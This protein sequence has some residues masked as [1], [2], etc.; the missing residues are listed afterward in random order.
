MFA[1]IEAYARG[2]LRD[3][4][5]LALTLLLP[6]IIYLLFAAIFGAGGQ[7]NIDAS[8]AFADLARSPA[9]QAARA[10]MRTSF[11]R[12]SERDSA[13]A[14]EASV[15]SGRADT[16][17]VLRTGDGPGLRIEI[18]GTGGREAATN[19]VAARMSAIHAATMGRTV[20]DGAVQRRRLGPVGD[21]QATYYAAAVAAMFMFFAAAHG[22]MGGLDERRSGLQARLVLASRGLAPVLGARLVWSTAVGV[23]QSIVI[24][25]VATPDLPSLAIWQIAAGLVTA[26][27]VGLAAAGFALMVIAACR[28][29]EQ[30]QPL[31]TFLV[32]VLAALGGSMAPRFLMPPAFQS[33]GW[34]T[35]HAWAIESWQTVIWL[36]RFD[37]NV[38]T[39]WIVLAGLGIGGWLVAFLIE[40]RRLPG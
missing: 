22:A 36:G 18:L 8:V 1:I 16:G 5:G 32:L 26:V 34:L 7:G 30:A 4:P 33:I 17:V 23:A 40:R 9:S 38:L 39:D 27:A 6:P 37:T 25:L 14:V 12:L 3:R 19:A 10:A 35:P 15:V 11:D 24:F 13:Q 2:F 29:R 28:S 21:F 31:S 20:D